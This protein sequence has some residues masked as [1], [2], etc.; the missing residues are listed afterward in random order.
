MTDAATVVEALLDPEVRW[1]ALVGPPGVGKSHLA[2]VAVE[3]LPSGAFAVV[4]RVSLAG[5]TFIVGVWPGVGGCHCG[6]IM[7]MAGKPFPSPTVMPCA[8][9]SNRS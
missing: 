6:W 5:P 4:R 8:Q 9:R 1:V 7:D 2:A 3:A